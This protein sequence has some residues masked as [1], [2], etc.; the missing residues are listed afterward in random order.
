M[1]LR[2]RINAKGRISTLLKRR[3]IWS[4]RYV[5]TSSLLLLVVMA[6]NKNHESSAQYRAKFSMRTRIKTGPH[7]S[8]KQPGKTRQEGKRRGNKK[9]NPGALARRARLMQ[10]GAGEE[11]ENRRAKTRNLSTT[12]DPVLK[13]GRHSDRIEAST[14]RPIRHAFATQPGPSNCAQAQK[15]LAAACCHHCQLHGRWIPRPWL[16]QAPKRQ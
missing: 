8:R 9:N 7:G 2:I 4:C 6:S 15:P 14:R 1:K 13:T 12:G 3:Q 11:K 5:A 16:L 10:A